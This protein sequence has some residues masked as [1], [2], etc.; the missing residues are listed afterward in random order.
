MVVS[1]VG[2]SVGGDGSNRRAADDVVEKIRS[3]GGTA[4]ADYHSVDEGDKTIETA[5]REFGRVD[6]L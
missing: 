6:I 5:I 2:A 1:D 3:T 4:V